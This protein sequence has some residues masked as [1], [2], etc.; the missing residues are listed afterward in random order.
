MHSIGAHRA[1]DAV[2]ALPTVT[3]DHKDQA[4]VEGSPAPEGSPVGLS[5][6]RC[7]R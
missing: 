2:V 6:T 3:K 7:I 1:P 5:A 4:A